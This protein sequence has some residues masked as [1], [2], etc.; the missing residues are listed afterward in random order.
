MHCRARQSPLIYNERGATA[1]NVTG[2]GIGTKPSSLLHFVRD[3]VVY[4]AGRINKTA[5]IF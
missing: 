5:E 2:I 1:N 3:L 4:S